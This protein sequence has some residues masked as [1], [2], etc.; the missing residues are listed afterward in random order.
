[1]KTRAMVLEAFGRPLVMRTFDVPPLEDGQVLVRMEAAGVCGSDVH[2]TGGG[3]PRTPLPLIPGHEGVGIVG[4]T[5]G[6]VRTIE[7]YLVEPGDR[8]IWN[9]GV[10]CGRCWFCRIA[11][12]P[13]LCPDRLVYG[14]NV[15]FD[16]PPRLNGCYADHI[17]LRRGTDLFTVP[18]DIDPAA[19]V[20]AS[21]SGATVAHAFDEAGVSMTGAAVVVQ[22][23]G[24]LGAWAAAFARRL[25]AETIFVI[26]GSP[27]RLALCREFGATH[28]LDRHAT[29]VEERRAEVLAVTAGRGADVVVEATGA[30]GAALEGIRLLRRGGVFLS[31]GYSQPSGTETVDFYRDIVLKNARVQ[32]VWVS[33]ASHLRDALSLVQSEPELFDRLVTHRFPMERADDALAAMADRSAMKAVLSFA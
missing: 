27:E 5:S 15:S 4:F 31:T 29:D 32:G 20:T 33:G 17:V 1:M 21:C 2:I 9:R 13:H 26:G 24:P 25:G 18:G 22:G 3:D 10:T 28:I 8:V 30:N 6:E 23:P 16:E 14:I 7:G 19:L 12:Q 11:G